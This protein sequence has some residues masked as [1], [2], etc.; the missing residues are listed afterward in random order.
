MNRIITLLLIFVSFSTSEIYSQWHSSSA[1]NDL[2]KEYQVVEDLMG[3]DRY[4]VEFIGDQSSIQSIVDE[5]NRKN[6][7]WYGGGTKYNYRSRPYHKIEFFRKDGMKEE[8]MYLAE[9][10]IKQERVDGMGEIYVKEIKAVSVD[11][12]GYLFKNVSVCN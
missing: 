6:E 5:L 3:M 9:N 12:V 2:V 11:Y 4:V 7:E 8:Y 10:I 1:Y